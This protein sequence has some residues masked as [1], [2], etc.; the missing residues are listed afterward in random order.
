MVSNGGTASAGEECRARGRVEEGLEEVGAPNIV[1][2]QR[3]SNSATRCAHRL[4]WAGRSR[5]WPT[6]SCR[7]RNVQLATLFKADLTGR[8]PRR[9]LHDVASRIRGPVEPSDADL[10]QLPKPRPHRSMS[11]ATVQPSRSP[12]EAAEIGP[13]SLVAPPVLGECLAHQ[14]PTLRQPLLRALAC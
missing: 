14:A 5:A 13:R 8:S 7:S 9:H 10:A 1:R 11:T 4:R 6:T 3:G 12:S 2:R